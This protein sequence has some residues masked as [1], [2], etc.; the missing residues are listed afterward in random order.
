MYAGSMVWSNMATAAVIIVVIGFTLLPIWPEFAKKIL[1]YFSVTFLIVTLLLVLIRFLIFLFMWL[2]GYEL[3]VFPRLFDESLSFVDSF[4]PIY[5]FDKGSPGQGYYRIGLLVLIIGFVYWACT[6]PT[7]FDG[8]VK[9][10]RDFLDDLYSGNLLADVAHESKV[11]IDRTRK[12]PNLEELLKEMEEEERLEQEARERAIEEALAADGRTQ[13]QID[14]DMLEALLRKEEEEDGAAEASVNPY[15]EV[16][17][18]GGDGRGEEGGEGEG[19]QNPADA[20]ADEP[21]L[22]DTETKS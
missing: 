22:E 4:K 11:S 3:W 19:V 5:S 21:I 20:A 13:E 18:E 9:A 16:E 12:V 14:D 17:E 7:E 10:Q 8:F 6:Q 15:G 1:W 2:L